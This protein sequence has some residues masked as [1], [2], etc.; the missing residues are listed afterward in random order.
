MQADDSPYKI[1]M[2]TINAEPSKVSMHIVN[3]KN[4][5]KFKLEIVA[6]EVSFIRALFV[7]QLFVLESIM[8][9]FLYC[10]RLERGLIIHK[11]HVLIDRAIQPD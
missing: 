7:L 8:Y 2:E 1:L 4:S 6:L 5:V 9:A 11:L 3:V 10:F